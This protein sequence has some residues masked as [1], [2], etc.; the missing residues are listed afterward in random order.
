[1]DKMVTMEAEVVEGLMVIVD[2]MMKYWVM[3]H[4]HVYEQKSGIHCEFEMK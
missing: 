3:T 1:M 4:K 2:S